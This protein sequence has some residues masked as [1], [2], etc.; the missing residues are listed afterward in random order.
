MAFSISR[1]VPASL[2][3]S[4]SL[5]CVSESTATAPPYML[6]SKLGSGSVPRAP[7]VIDTKV[8][9]LLFLRQLAIRPQRHR[10]FDVVPS[11]IP[12]TGWNQ[13]Y[14]GDRHCV[15]YPTQQQ[16]RDVTVAA[17]DLC[18]ITLGNA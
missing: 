7:A 4:G 3:C 18:N 10:S 16:N 13:I 2:M 9:R 6:R 8:A 5:S 14:Q 11:E 15:R 1:Q 12:L 17:F